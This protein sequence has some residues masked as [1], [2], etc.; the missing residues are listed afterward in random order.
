MDGIFSILVLFGII[1]SIVKWVK[2]QGSGQQGSGTAPDQS[3]KR[4]LGDIAQT[5]DTTLSGKPAQQPSLPPTVKPAPAF[6]PGGEGT[7]GGEG[8]GA[9]GPTQR[10]L[11]S[12][13]ETAASPYTFFSGSQLR[14]SE[15]G[16]AW[17][18]SLSGTEGAVGFTAKL[19]D[20]S[21]A[22]SSA[23]EAV[24][25]LQLRFDRDSLVQA[26]VMQEILARPQ[27]RRRRWSTH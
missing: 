20:T 3:W 27:D 13:S 10:A 25:N 23:Q 11:F 1:S 9:G 18:G 8:Y 22:T 21:P 15:Q 5:L 2:K 19:A 4:M 7:Y 12:A 17:H 6:A 14:P 24:P 16:E 26:V